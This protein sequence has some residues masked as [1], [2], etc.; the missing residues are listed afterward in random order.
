[1]KVGLLALGAVSAGIATWAVGG[2]SFLFVLPF[3]LYAASPRLFLSR[4]S[5]LIEGRLGTVLLT[6]LL[7]M[8]VI[9]H[10][11]VTTSDSSTA[12]L[13]IFFLTVYQWL[14][15][16]VAYIVLRTSHAKGER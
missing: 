16:L 9:I 3:A 7:G 4:T 15:I 5:P 12:I 13:G 11:A 14:A 2:G 6:L 1:M 8:T 10:L